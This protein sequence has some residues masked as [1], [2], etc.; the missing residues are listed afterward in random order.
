MQG[1]DQE[2]RLFV[3]SVCRDFPRLHRM[4]QLDEVFLLLA[5]FRSLSLALPPN[6]SLVALNLPGPLSLGRALSV[7]LL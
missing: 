1:E 7:L 4:S 5:H 3:E 2:A 6:L